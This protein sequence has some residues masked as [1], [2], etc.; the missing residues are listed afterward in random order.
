MA[1]SISK[2]PEQREG[3]NKCEVVWHFC[4]HQSRRCTA[5]RCEWGQPTQAIGLSGYPANGTRECYDQSAPRVNF[6][7]PVLYRFNLITEHGNP[8]H[9]KMW[10]VVIPHNGAVTGTNGAPGRPVR[11]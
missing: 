6:P 1:G 4:S 7:M 5:R 10:G 3:L 9:P 2:G 8:I 11:L